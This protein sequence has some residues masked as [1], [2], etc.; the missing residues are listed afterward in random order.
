[1]AVPRKPSKS[2]EDFLINTTSD[3]QPYTPDPE[4]EALFST[5]KMSLQ[6]LD[7]LVKN[8]DEAFKGLKK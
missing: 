4:I 3:L 7:A 8:M 6:E 1:M 2:N 5:N